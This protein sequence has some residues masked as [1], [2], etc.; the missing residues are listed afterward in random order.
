[1]NEVITQRALEPQT[2][3]SATEVEEHC[4]VSIVLAAYNEESCIVE[5]LQTIR[6]AMQSSPFSYE[7]I[8]VDDGSSDSTATLVS[9]ANW[10]RLL[11]HRVNTG[12]G[13]ARKTG[14]LAARGDVVV[15]SDVDMSYPNDRIPDLVQ[16]LVNSGSD[17]VV[18][19]RDSERGTLRLLRVPAK[20]LIRKLACFLTGS[21]IPD[22]NSGLRAFRRDVAMQ[23]IDLLP[24]G[25]SCVTTITLAF[26]CN[27]HSVEYVPIHYRKRS[28]VSKFHPFKDTYRYMTQVARMVTYFEPLKV[29]LPVSLTM[30]GL[31]V[32]SSVANLVRTG[33]MQEMDL[34]IIVAGILIGVLG[35][36]ADLFVQYQRKMERMISSISKSGKRQQSSFLDRHQEY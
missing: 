20:F 3:A 12:S 27:G 32:L 18:G 28:G 10:V 9:G 8:V 17:Q 31:G 16:H 34:I 5:E 24:K 19:A 13:A 11:R 23:Y 2:A 36:V 6:K 21:N 4:D 26:L 14:T 22:L 15:W 35:L 33:S 25:F 30:L 1:M 29:F 7:V